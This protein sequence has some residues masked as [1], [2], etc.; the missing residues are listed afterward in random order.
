MTAQPP[1][2]EL[3]EVRHRYGPRTVLG[4]PRLSILRGETLG[5]VGPSG[6]GKSTLLRLLQGL[7]RPTEGAIRI[8]GAPMPHP[9]PLPLARRITTVFQRPVLLYRTVR[10]NVLSGCACAAARRRRRPSRCWNAS[11]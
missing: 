2:F 11:A 4:I 9:L 5:V 7:E 10:D 8:D 1:V 6:A 3:V